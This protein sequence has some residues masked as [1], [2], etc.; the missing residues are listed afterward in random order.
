LS[1]GLLQIDFKQTEAGE[2]NLEQ[3]QAALK[4]LMRE[5]PENLGRRA[6]LARLQ[7]AVGIAHLRAGRSEEAAALFA[8]VA[9]SI[10]AAP[11]TG[12]GSGDLTGVSDSLAGA[13]GRFGL[14]VEAAALQRQALMPR[15]EPQATWPWSLAAHYC[16]LQGDREGFNRIAV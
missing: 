3:A 15:G 9:E 2:R 7:L 10:A 4:A 12:E 16:L 13:Y 14:W 1:V 8:G 6:A 11:K 5:E